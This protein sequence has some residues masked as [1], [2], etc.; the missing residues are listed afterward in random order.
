MCELVS[1]SPREAKASY[2]YKKDERKEREEGEREGEKGGRSDENYN[3]HRT[4]RE[5]F[6]DD[7]FSIYFRDHS[8]Q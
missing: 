8:S 2:K 4:P 5:R 7:V 1:F 3:A 6:D